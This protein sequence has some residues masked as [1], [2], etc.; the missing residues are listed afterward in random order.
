MAKDIYMRNGDDYLD[1]QE[2]ASGVSFTPTSYLASDNCQDVFYEIQDAID[3]N[4][5]LF[6]KNILDSSITG[7]ILKIIR[8]MDFLFV[9][10][11]ESVESVTY[12]NVSVYDINGRILINPYRLMAYPAFLY[13]VCI[14]RDEIC[15]LF[16][17]L[18]DDQAYSRAYF[19]KTYVDL[20]TN[21]PQITISKESTWYKILAPN[22]V[23]LLKYLGSNIFTYVR[24]RDSAHLYIQSAGYK[25]GTKIE[26]SDP[27]GILTN[28]INMYC[29][30]GN[31][32]I[33]VYGSNYILA[34]VQNG[35][36][37]AKGTPQS[38][39]SNF[40]GHGLS[41]IDGY[42]YYNDGNTLYKTTIDPFN[43]SVVTNILDIKHVDFVNN[44]NM[45][46]FDTY[47]Y[48]RK[49]TRTIATKRQDTL[50]D[51]DKFQYGY[52]DNQYPDGRFMCIGGTATG[53]SIYETNPY[54]KGYG[55]S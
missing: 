10:K 47:V 9:F 15:I 32:F 24:G 22:S 4:G 37:T 49:G 23:N 12:I 1:V 38:Y 39:T 53:T 50:G 40:I 46:S 3:C 30:C 19:I 33:V 28:S 13:D 8:Y 26:I 43:P 5:K 29:V 6:E 2:R 14:N 7:D 52:I 25:Y 17:D 44:M 34:T 45:W 20:A 16:K 31:I 35:A 21:M 55:V 41:P 18:T 48:C 36:I 51:I 54:I 27:N 42:Y 11:H